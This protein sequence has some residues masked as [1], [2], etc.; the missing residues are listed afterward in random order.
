MTMKSIKER[1]WDYLI[2]GVVSNTPEDCAVIYNSLTDDEKDTLK[3]MMRHP[4]DLS[5]KGNAQYS[6]ASSW[7]IEEGLATYVN[8]DGY[9]YLAAT[10]MGS[11]VMIGVN[12]GNQGND[13]NSNKG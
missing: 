2:E 10:I 1:V 5:D 8:F 13:D 4:I 6:K 11:R 3:E 12:K 9:D 7:L